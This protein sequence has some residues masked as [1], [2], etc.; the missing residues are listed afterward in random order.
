MSASK[1]NT[2][3]FIVLGGGCFGSFYVRQLLRG[4]D[5]LG[6]GSIHV[7]DRDE[8]CRVRREYGDVARVVYHIQ[9]WKQFLF[10]YFDRALSRRLGGE[11]V[12]DRYVPP[13]FAPH[14]LMELFIEKARLE[15]SELKFERRPFEKTVGTPVDMALPAGTRALSFA[16]WTCPASCIEPPTCPHTRGPK[17]WDMKE[18]LQ[19]HFDSLH[20]FQCRHYAMGV[21]TIAVNDIVD[22]YLRFRET[23]QR[24][25]RHLAAMASVSSCHGLIG[26]VEVTRA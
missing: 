26:L 6:V 1:S 7:V 4:A 15:F 3:D 19:G 16:T 23:L 21:G 17:D 18:H 25:G 24:P 5:R 12:Q 20:V 9:D 13:T 10:P 14:V 22:E 8:N 2:I 11:E